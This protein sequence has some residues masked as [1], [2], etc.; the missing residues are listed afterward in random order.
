MIAVAGLAR[1]KSGAREA[2]EV[3]A[4]ASWSLTELGPLAETVTS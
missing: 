2:L 4:R 3:R 1:L